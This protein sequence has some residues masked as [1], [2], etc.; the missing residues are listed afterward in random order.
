MWSFFNLV[1]ILIIVQCAIG[2]PVSLD[3]VSTRGKEILP[4]ENQ[5]SDSNQE[6]PKKHMISILSNN[7]HKKKY[8]SVD[9]EE[10]DPKA[11]DLLKP[12]W[13]KSGENNTFDDKDIDDEE[14]DGPS[15]VPKDIDNVSE[16]LDDELTKGTKTTDILG[17]N[18]KSQKIKINDNAYNFGKVKKSA[19]LHEKINVWSIVGW[20]EVHEGQYSHY[21]VSLTGRLNVGMYASVD[22]TLTDIKTNKADYSDFHEAVE[23]SI[24][25]YVGPGKITFSGNKLTFMA[26]NDGDFFDGLLIN[27]LIVADALA[28]GQEDFEVSLSNPSS[29]NGVHV[30]LGRKSVITTISATSGDIAKA[31]SIGTFASARDFCNDKMSNK[32]TQCLPG[33]NYLGVGF[34]L[35]KAGEDNEAFS[36]T[37]AVIAFHSRHWKKNPNVL[38]DVRSVY[39]PSEQEGSWESRIRDISM[40]SLT[41]WNS[42][43]KNIEPLECQI[44]NLKN[45]SCWKI[46][47]YYGE[48]F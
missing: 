40:N 31:S 25:S 22:L 21:M 35:S 24:R 18:G 3:V 45:A 16:D 9:K 1:I 14:I 11:S 8:D 17:N 19:N 15:E 48:I 32:E 10:A 30:V 12:G 46:K 26:T 4:N 39:V 20:T 29:N 34:D 37:E 6:N 2:L 5:S 36:D 27:L 13:T 28:E 33:L 47:S 7:K 38:P 41:K 43:K 23:K 44:W 42:K